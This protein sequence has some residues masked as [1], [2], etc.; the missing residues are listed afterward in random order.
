[1]IEPRLAPVKPRVVS[2]LTGDALLLE[3]EVQALLEAQVRGAVRIVGPPGSGKTTALLHLAAVFPP[4]S[5]LVF[6][7]E[8]AQFLWGNLDHPGTKLAIFATKNQGVQA[9]RA[10]YQLASWGDDE[11]LEYLL[12]V[13]PERCASVMRRLGAGRCNKSLMGIPELWR[14]VLDEMAVDESL[15]GVRDAL[16]HFLSRE[17]ECEE[18]AKVVRTWSF[19]AVCATEPALPLDDKEIRRFVCSDLLRRALRHIPVRLTLGVERLLADLL[20]GEPCDSLR[21]RLSPALIRATGTTAARSPRILENLKRLLE[22]DDITCHAMAASILHGTDTGWVPQR[23]ALPFLRE[24]YLPDVAWPYVNLAGVNLSGAEVS[25]AYL[26]GAVLDGAIANGTNLQ[27]ARLQGASMKAFNGSGANLSRADLASANAERAVLRGADLQR[28]QLEGASLRGVEFHS[29][30]LMGAC[31]LQADLTGAMFQRA[32]IAEADFTGA[33]LEAAGLSGLRL[34]GATFSGARFPRAD[35]DGCDLE[36]LCLPGTDFSNTILRN[37]LL[38][39]AWMPEARFENAALCNAGLADIN[40]EGADLRNADLR[41]AS[42]HAGSSRSGL[43]GSPIACEGSRTGFYT[44]ESEEQYFKAP[45]QIRKA[46]LRGADLR[47]ARVDGVDFYLVD[48]RD[49]LYDPEQE[50][51]F[52]RCRAIL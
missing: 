41:G 43:V 44:D 23:D 28:A 11:C 31:F 16:R 42:F 50:E 15:A 35:L 20:Q 45:E 27:H 26:N 34:R 32:R 9:T 2:P 47:G 25:N 51:H 17:L 7:D 1:M 3:N 5:G 14:I 21:R 19:G 36:Y 38:T 6:V 40:W 4:D 39:G 12:A 29:S 22:R 52:R 33:N 24:A 18:L 10:V 13:H 30:D 8:S 48:L 49:A 37:A 46:N